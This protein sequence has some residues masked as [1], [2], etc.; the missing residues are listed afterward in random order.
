M[1]VNMAY[2]LQIGLSRSQHRR[3]NWV[4]WDMRAKIM[5]TI[6]IMIRWEA[7]ELQ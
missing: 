4:I 7:Q 2:T 5:F 6:F 3:K 1:E